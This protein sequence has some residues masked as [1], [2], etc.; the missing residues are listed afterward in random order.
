MVERHLDQEAVELLLSRLTWPSPMVR[1]RTAIAVADLLVGPDSSV[2]QASLLKWTREQTLESIVAL[3]LLPICR[4]KDAGLGFQVPHTVLMAAVG[5]PSLLSHLLLRDLGVSAAT[6]PAVES[7]HSGR[8]PAGFQPRPFF[9]Q[10]ARSFVAPVFSRRAETIERSALLPFRRQWAFEWE[11]LLETE[12]MTP[13]TAPLWF[14]GQQ[15]GEHLLIL[16]TKLSDIYHSAYLRALAWA[17]ST[18]QIHLDHVLS[19]AAG[20]CPIDLELWKMKPGRRPAWWPSVQESEG[21]VDI[22]PGRIWA[23]VTRLWEEQRPEGRES[24]L[25]AAGGHVHEVREAAYDL[26]ISGVFQAADGPVAGKAEEVFERCCPM[27]RASMEPL[28]YSGSLRMVPPADLAIRS[29]DW[30]VVPASGYV[31]APA[32]DRWQFWRVCRGL[33]LPS[34]FLTDTPLTFRYSTDAIEVS[35]ATGVRAW[36][37]DW[38]DGVRE[39]LLANLQPRS[40]YVLTAD[41]DMVHGFAARTGSTFSWVCRLTTYQR[42]YEYGS[43]EVANF[44]ATFGTRGVIIPR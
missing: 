23:A 13:S 30:S 37:H 15:D 33:R 32:S 27:L 40:G 11:A 24:V 42:R 38:T 36:L 7:L 9:E 14:R 26:E 19:L 31:M 18:G 4:A 34:P 8:A 44:Y 22:T 39:K 35:D 25:L 12:G 41:A 6:L 28:R 2:V 43:F 10:N 3:G 21:S 5:R 20:I 16:D 17:A 1:E 29:G